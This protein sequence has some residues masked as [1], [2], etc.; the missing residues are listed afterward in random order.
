MKKQP[1]AR[2]MTN[3][4]ATISLTFVAADWLRGLC[5]F[6]SR[7]INEPAMETQAHSVD[8]PKLRFPYGMEKQNAFFDLF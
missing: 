7:P 3:E 8:E 6:F 2:A 4:Q 1:K 5:Y